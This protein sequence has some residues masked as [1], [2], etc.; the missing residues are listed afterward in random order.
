VAAGFWPDVLDASARPSLRTTL[1]TLRRS[2]GEEAAGCIVAGRDRVEQIAHGPV[3]LG[4]GR[5]TGN[6]P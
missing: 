3:L 1:T 6:V 2:L 5:R 4:V